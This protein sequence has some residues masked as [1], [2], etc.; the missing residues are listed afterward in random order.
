MWR[1]GALIV[2]VWAGLVQA[3]DRRV[4]FFGNSLIHHLTDSDDTA[5]PHWL[6][7][8][9]KAGGQSFAAD[10][11]W[12][13]PADF[14]RNLPPEPNWSFDAVTPALG[15]RSFRRAGLT[16]IVTNPANF[17]QADP[18]DADVQ[19]GSAVDL[20]ARLFDWA[21]GQAPDARLWIYE[22]WGWIGDENFPPDAGALA[23][24]HAFNAGDQHDWYQT[25]QMLVADQLDRPVGL[26]PVASVLARLLQ[27]EPFAAIPVTDLYSDGA[28]HGTA[29]VYLLAAMVT[30]VTLS[31]TLPPEPPLSDA[32]HPILRAN[33]ALAAAQ[34]YA[35]TTGAV[36]PQ[37][38]TLSLP[39]TGLENPSGAMGLSGIADW[40]TQLPF[41]DQM[42]S[43]RPWV[44]HSADT[45]GAW[46]FEDLLAGGYLGPDGWPLRLPDGAAAIET[47][48]LT[49][50]PE[51]TAGVTGRYVLR[52]QGQGDLSI[53][54]R[55]TDIDIRDREIRF[56]T[57]PG[58][59]TV[60]IA[61][62]ATDPADPIRAI[63]VVREDQLDLYDGG[64]TFNPLFLRQIRDLRMV[65]FM[66]WMNTNG[67]PVVTWDDGPQPDDFSYMW[68]GV[69]A[70]VLVDLANQIG[71]DPWFTLP[72]QADDA[73]VTRF[74]TYVHDHLDPRL[75]AHAEWS[76][77]VWNWQFPQTSW[78][79]EQAQA[80]WGVEGGDAWMQFN[81][82][83][84]AEV[85]DLWT[86][87]F[88]D[89]PDRLVRV[90]ATQTAW[91]GLEI[92]MLDAPLRVAEGLRPPVDSFDAYAVTGYV[93]GDMG[94][95]PMPGRIR[96]WLAEGGT[97]AAVAGATAH[98]RDQS[99]AE[100]VDQFLPYQVQV[101]RDRGLRLVM[102]EGGT[103]VVGGMDVVDDQALTDF[104][105]A[106]NY[107]PGMAGVYADLITAWHAAGGTAFNA[108]V[109]LGAPSKRGSWGHARW[110]GDTNP[111]QVTVAAFASLPPAWDEPRAP[112]TFLH[113]VLRRGTDG[114]DRIVGTPEED[115][116]LGGAGDDEF[117]AGPGDRVHGGAGTDLVLL[118]GDAADWT[119]TPGLAI[120]AAGQVRLTEVEVVRFTGSG[121]TVQMP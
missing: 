92:P 29:T 33:Y 73:F 50:M 71:A 13:F 32:V 102:Y 51:E 7:L 16:D 4:F 65:R 97:A 108:F 103:H 94:Y 62:S 79:A 119:L 83:R 111:R 114:P 70:A 31:G 37:G 68:R 30:H 23:D 12:G 118:P 55:A 8:M 116:L 74:A 41:L 35:L 76:N 3:E 87:V 34:V 9:A 19:D 52:W 77:E 47:F 85:A 26:I 22:G 17:I 2:W 14:A 91:T 61:I 18:P 38:A 66:D 90:V 53:G 78:A 58:L 112:G 120:S 60:P 96:D 43:A 25:Y 86:A 63:T 95:D 81:G 67:S 93:G 39:E 36:I 106:L 40:S 88:A 82:H 20:T 10:G 89:A 113:G 110:L 84:A 1:W 99:L 46:T 117:E 49:D 6:A 107:S 105:I 121:E 15:D 80:R 104:Y 100:Y 75:R 24:W 27:Q 54:G 59:G 21:D 48:I 5:V 98:L 56:N 115:D 57:T 44:A 42:K 11:V 72:H 28:P 69:P 45:W 109:D 64:A 101:A